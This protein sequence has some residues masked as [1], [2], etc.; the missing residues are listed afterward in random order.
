[1]KLLRKNVLSCPGCSG[2]IVFSLMTLSTSVW[3]MS[4]PAPAD[5]PQ[6]EVTDISLEI[7][8]SAATPL[9]GLTIEQGDWYSPSAPLMLWQGMDHEWRRFIVA[10]NDGRIP[11][12][13]SSLTN[14]L[15]PQADAQWQA[16]FAQD[17]GVDGNYM[18]PLTQGQKL[19][20]IDY[21]LNSVRF[22]WKDLLQESDLSQGGVPQARNKIRY[23]VTLPASPS[24]SQSQLALQGIDLSLQCHDSDQPADQPCNSNGMWPYLLAVQLGECDLSDG[25]YFCPLEVDI[26]RSW[27]PNQGGVPGLGETKPLNQQLSY[28]LDVHLVAIRNPYNILA[29]SPVKKVQ[30]SHDLLNYQALEHPLTLQGEAGY[31]NGTALIKGFGFMLTK[32]EKVGGQWIGFNPDLRQRG[33]YLARLQFMLNNPA[34]NSQT[35]SLNVK[36][37]MH[38]WAPETVVDSR[39]HSMMKL[40]LLQTQEPSSGHMAKGQ[41]CLNSKAEAP[42]YS[43]W[44]NCNRQTKAALEKFGGVER[45][46]QTVPLVPAVSD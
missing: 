17:T 3:S 5:P 40:Q 29:F 24:V 7:Q 26:Y 18:H 9:S 39:V 21:A 43:L 14:F 27:T 15:Q 16:T 32:P 10:A 13:I 34:Y 31:S 46:R 2:F 36:P 45:A 38:I 42:F 4:A 30:H 11:H 1:M 19:M 20:G 37:A 44:K 41:L 25:R 35:G 28:Q 23:L 6:Q 8:R 22:S 12:R 33:R